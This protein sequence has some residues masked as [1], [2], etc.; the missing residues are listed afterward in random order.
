MTFGIPKLFLNIMEK[1]LSRIFG[2]MNIL[3]NFFMVH[4]FLGWGK[5]G[6][7]EGCMSPVKGM[8]SG[9]SGPPRGN[10]LLRSVAKCNQVSFTNKNTQIY[11][12]TC[13]TSRYK[14]P[15]EKAN[16]LLVIGPIHILHSYAH[17]QT[18]LRYRQG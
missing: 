15:T 5:A 9:G 11:L 10:S 13:G 17:S 16:E 12:L 2:D 7:S 8:L 18:R 6:T 4:R 1:T 14:T 3:E